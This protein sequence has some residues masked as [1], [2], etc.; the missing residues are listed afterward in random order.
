MSNTILAGNL[1]PTSN[2]D[3][4]GTIDSLGHNLIQNVSAGCNIIGD[5]T[6]NIEGEDPAMFPLSDNGGATWTHALAMDSPAVD[7]GE[8]ITCE[9]DD[10]REFSRPFGSTCDMGAYERGPFIYNP[11]VFRE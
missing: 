7:A 3:C 2:P 4:Y 1:D 9:P 10:Q 11:I 5:I 8:N 6:G